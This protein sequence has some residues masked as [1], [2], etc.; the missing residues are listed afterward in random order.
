MRRWQVWS[1]GVLVLVLGAL[2][3]AA[4]IGRLPGV[5]FARPPAVQTDP[6]SASIA[7]GETPAGWTG[8]AKTVMPAVVNISSA[9]TI[10]GGPGSSPF[11]SDPFFRFFQRPDMQPRR[12]KSLGSGTIVTADGYVLTNNHVIEGATDIR[13]TLADRRELTAKLIGGDAKTDIAVIQLPG[14]NFP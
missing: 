7:T 2:L 14:S 1:F 12:E 8:V 11:F 9:R 5:R 4:A 3:I 13:V 10:R 6:G